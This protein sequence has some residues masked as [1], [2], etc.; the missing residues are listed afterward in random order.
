MPHFLIVS[1]SSSRA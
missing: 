1:H